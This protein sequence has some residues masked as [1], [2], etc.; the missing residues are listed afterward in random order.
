MPKQSNPEALYVTGESRTWDEH[1]RTIE[2]VEYIGADGGV[3]PWYELRKPPMSK[4]Q[5]FWNC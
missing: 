1:H 3:N 2:K 5:R 4:S